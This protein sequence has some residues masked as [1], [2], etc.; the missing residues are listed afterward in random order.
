[1]THNKYKLQNKGEKL[2][3]AK[4]TPN[5]KSFAVETYW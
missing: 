2:K 1:M 5:K 4:E 3:A